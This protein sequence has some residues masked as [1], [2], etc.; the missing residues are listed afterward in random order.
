[1]KKID[2]YSLADIVYVHRVVVG[3]SNPQNM[4][5]EGIIQR[6]MEEVN[7][8]LTQYPKGRIIGIEKNV[9]LLNFGEH[10]SILQY[11]VYHIGFVRKPDNLK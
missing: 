11:L 4:A 5:D 6:Q 3:C 8:C 7:R 2:C 1:M 10:Q 9:Y